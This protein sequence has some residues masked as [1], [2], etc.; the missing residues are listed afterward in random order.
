[1]DPSAIADFL[2]E[3][4]QLVTGYWRSRVLRIHG[5]GGIFTLAD[6][7]LDPQYNVDFTNLKDD[8]TRYQRGGREY[9]RPYGWNRIALNVKNQYKSTAWLGGI[10]GGI[11][12]DGVE[13]EWAVSYHGTKRRFA[14]DI[15][16]T[17]YDL[18]KGERFLYGRG[19]YSTPDPEI[20][21]EYA[22]EF[23]Y[24]GKRYKVI[25]QNR[26]NMEDT[27]HVEAMDYYVTKNENNIRAYG[28]LFKEAK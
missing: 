14:E 11:R 24:R 7:V 19:I 1:M 5:G 13:G 21:E 25:L 2:S 3:A 12:A 28:L 23:K 20:A 16:R 27:E 6:E 9:I 15:A 17:K 8:G 10:G 22:Q 18:A 26:V 4:L